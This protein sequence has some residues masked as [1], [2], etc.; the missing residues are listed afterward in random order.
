MEKRQRELGLETKQLLESFTVTAWG[1]VPTYEQILADFPNIVPKA[2][3]LSALEQRLA[4]F[5]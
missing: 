2:S 4:R 5:S 3:N 1:T